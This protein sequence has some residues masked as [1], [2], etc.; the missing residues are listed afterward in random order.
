VKQIDTTPITINGEEYY[1]L[2][3]FAHLTNRHTS[4]ISMLFNKGN[5]IRT[6]NGIKIGGK[7]LIC[8]AEVSEFPFD[9]RKEKQ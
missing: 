2:E 1:T 7:P 6:L 9:S 5:K 4:H 8:I 3:Q